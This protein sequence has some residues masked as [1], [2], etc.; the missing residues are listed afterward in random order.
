MNSLFGTQLSTEEI[1]WYAAWSKK[2]SLGQYMQD[3]S[4]GTYLRTGIGWPFGTQLR[5]KRGF[6]VHS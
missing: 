4:F 2:S 5:A 6:W 3:K 1:N